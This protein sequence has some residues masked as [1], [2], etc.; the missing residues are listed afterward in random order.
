MSDRFARSLSASRPPSFWRGRHPLTSHVLA[1]SASRGPFGRECHVSSTRRVTGRPSIRAL[2]LDPEPVRPRYGTRHTS[3]RLRRERRASGCNQRREIAAHAHA[4]RQRRA[5]AEPSRARAVRPLV[6]VM[7]RLDLWLRVDPIRRIVT[8]PE[9]LNLSVPRRPCGST[10]G[11]AG[12]AGL[13]RIG[14]D[15]LRRWPW[16]E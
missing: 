14:W 12:L 3:H 4:Y 13:P 8:I 7:P 16:R 11:T 5:H 6:G 2:N 1:C 10:G 15:R 9:L